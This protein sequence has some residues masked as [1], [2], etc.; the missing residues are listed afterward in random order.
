MKLNLNFAS[1]I[2]AAVMVLLLCSHAEAQRKISGKVTSSTDNQ[3]VVGATIKIKNTNTG[4]VA[5]PDGSFSLNVKSNKDVLVVS[6]I[7]FKTQEILV[8]NASTI[9]V[10]LEEAASSLNEIVVTGYTTQK[11]KDI[12]GAVSIVNVKDLT[13]TPTGG[14]DQML[15]GRVAGLT[16]ITSG[17]PGAGSNIRLRGI[18]SFGDATPLY[19]IDGVPGDINNL[20]VNDIESIQVLKDAGAAAIYG[21]RASTGV[22]IVTTK[23]GKSGR[24]VITYDGYYG[25]QRPLKRGFNILNPQEQADLTW[26]ALKNSGQVGANGNPSSPQY[27]NGPTPVL[28]DYILPSGAK[29]GDP[30]VNPALYNI[31]FSKPLYQIVRANKVG[32]DWF[33]EIFQP[34]PIQSHTLSA[35]GGSDKGQYL[36]SLG[37]FNQ[38]GTLIG[39]YLKRYSVRANTEFNIKNHIRVGENLQIYYKNNP[40]IGNQSEGNEISQTYR[41]QAIVPV[42]DIKGNFAGA[43]GAGLGNGSNPV[44]RRIRAKDDRGNTWNIFGNVFAEVDFLKYFTARTSFGGT[45]NNYYYY[46]YGFRTYENAENNGSNSFSENAGYNSSY[47]WTNT[48]TFNKTFLDKHSVKLLLGSEAINNYGRQVGGSRIN[49]FTDDPSYRV[50]SNGSPTGQTNYS[51]AYNSSN[52]AVFGRLDYGFNDKYLLSG[53]VRRDGSSKFGPQNRYGYFPAV[54]AAWRI[55]KEGFM[56]SISWITDLKIRGSWGKLGNDRIDPNNQFTLFGGGPGDAY[57]DITGSSTSAVQ[58]FRPTR[59]GNPKGRWQG[60]VASNVGVDA[61]LFNGEL[62]VTADFYQKKID[63]LLFPLI[64]PATV[65]GASSPFVNVGNI[66]NKGLDL[67]IDKKGRL[68]NGLRYDVGLTLTTYDNKITKITDD[69]QFF[70]SG[71]SRIGDFVRNQV[72]HPASAFYGYKVI[73]LFQSTDDVSKS[74]T[75]N[76]AAPGRFKYQDTNGDGK[77]TAD[78]RTFIGNPNPKFTYGLNVGLSYK[79]FDLTAFFYG[80][81]GNDVVNYVRWW[82]DFFPSFQGGKSKDALYNSWTPQRPNAKVPI[83]ENVSN[84][85]NNGVVNSYYIENGSYFRCKSLILGYTIPASKLQRLGID[86]L[87]VYL[88]SAN[89]FTITKYTGLDPELAGSNSAFGIDYGNYPDNQKQYIL[90]VNLSF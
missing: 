53:T 14:V 67:L 81:Y 79:N 10:S 60:D 31:D 83:V 33:H 87:R 90:G 82:T 86:R 84:F 9:N 24:A 28:P 50:L 58:G 15:Q 12:T 69:A 54:S 5:G 68:A 40:Q 34:A 64:L 77:I 20:N 16:V 1:F 22:I 73:G 35:S 8:G 56:R 70:T 4:T 41:M 78:D 47:T 61:L 75:Q 38:Q 43:R 30:S 25:T 89:L 66:E 52:Y 59:I 63:G 42:Y 49:Y 3:P 7:G 29:E 62:E 72:G 2:T 18:A 55:S 80:S 36:F 6:F 74:P 45:L 88:Q 26:L 48:L 39:T 32:T 44:A 51:F 76:G 21:V 27:G 11:K 13:S 57:Y 65:G 71:G 17:Q 19:I 37:Y 23:K 85:S 46:F